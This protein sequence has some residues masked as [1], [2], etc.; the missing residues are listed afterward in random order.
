KDKVNKARKDRGEDYEIVR[1]PRRKEVRP[2][3]LP[4]DGCKPRYAAVLQIQNL[5]AI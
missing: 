4:P 2:A 5:G 1:G 3:L